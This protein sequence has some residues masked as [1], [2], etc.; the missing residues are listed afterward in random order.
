MLPRFNIWLHEG[1]R[2]LSMGLNG[3]G[4]GFFT[5]PLHSNFEKNHWVHN[6][7]SLSMYM[8]INSIEHYQKICYLV[9]Q[10]HGIASPHGHY[11]SEVL[12]HCGKLPKETSPRV[13]T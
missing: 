9:G 13:L 8:Y 7:V 1:S 2:I 6:G 12:T 10:C 11:F 4:Q 5:R 3:S